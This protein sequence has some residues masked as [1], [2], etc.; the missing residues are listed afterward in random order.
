MVITNENVRLIPVEH[1]SSIDRLFDYIPDIIEKANNMMNCCI[2]NKKEQT[3][4][5]LNQ[6]TKK[7]NK[8]TKENKH[9]KVEENIKENVDNVVKKVHRTKESIPDEV[10]Y[11]FEYAE[12]ADEDDEI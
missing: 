10:S 6:M 12:T 4:K 3:E 1:S 7:E 9:I 11:E 5:I 2:K 8:N